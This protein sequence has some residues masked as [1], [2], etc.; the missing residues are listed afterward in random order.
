VR[1]RLA[2]VKEITPA[3]HKV[4]TS[5]EEIDYDILVLATGTETNFFGNQQLSENTFPMKSTV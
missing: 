5:H 3:E 2:E 1:I 4:V